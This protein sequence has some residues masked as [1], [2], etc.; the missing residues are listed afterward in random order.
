MY[1]FLLFSVYVMFFVPTISTALISAVYKEQS[2]LDTEIEAQM[3]HYLVKFEVLEKEDISYELY[4]AILSKAEKGI[5]DLN[6]RFQAPFNLRLFDI[7][8]R[9]HDRYSKYVVEFITFYRTEIQQNSEEPEPIS[10]T[11]RIV[12]S[13]SNEK[14]YVSS[15]T[16]C[17]DNKTNKKVKTS[18]FLD[19][20]YDLYEI[21]N[22][23]PE[24]KP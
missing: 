11:C 7:K 4:M 5:L 12:I 21:T 8:M 18:K 1:R 19:Y 24:E 6:P 16:R 20:I 2:P 23:F 15:T 13:L 9:K 22:E 3:E 14:L 10:A 17:M